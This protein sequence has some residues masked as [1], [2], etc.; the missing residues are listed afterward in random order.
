MATWIKEAASP[1]FNPT[2]LHDAD[3]HAGRAAQTVKILVGFF[4]AST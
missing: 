4:F 1:S 3:H 2:I